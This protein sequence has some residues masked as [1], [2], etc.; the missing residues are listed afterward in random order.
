MYS[1]YMKV[2]YRREQVAFSN[3]G[4]SPS[5][6]KPALV[7]K[8][9]KKNNKPIEIVS[10]AP[11]TR[12]QIAS[13]HEID[14]VNAV[15]DLKQAN[16]FGNLNNDVADS[17]PYTNGSF[18]AAAACA[19]AE[20][21]ITCSPTSGFHHAHYARGG[22]YCTFNGLIIAAQ[23]LKKDNPDLQVGIIDCDAHYGDGTAQ[24]ISRLRLDFI[25][26][27]TLGGD[28]EK[29][30]TQWLFN[31]ERIV[32]SFK[33]CG[34]VF[35]QA[36]ADPHIDDPL[37]GRLTTTTMRLRDRIV[38]NLYTQYG[39]PIVWNLAGGYQSQVGKVIFLHTNTLT[40]S[41]AA[42]SFCQ[43]GAGNS[44]MKLWKRCRLACGAGLAATKHSLAFWR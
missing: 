18:Y 13:A 4:F 23:L 20:R 5:A 33:D 36:G 15:L 12:T 27:Y 38:F 2:F 14:Y 43:K 11:L 44:L 3:N 26:H 31:F 25:K 40:E 24:I 41:F 30:N 21:T 28:G 10:F 1:S 42:L 35:Y 17:L 29:D 22:G 16:G 6:K 34:I 8:Q 9:W 7:V 32:N 39:I 37:G 19:L